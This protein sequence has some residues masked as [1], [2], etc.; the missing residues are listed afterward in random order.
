MAGGKMSP[1]QKMIN[2]MYL[3]LIALLALNVSKEIIKAFNLMENSLNTSTKNL[4]AKNE[5][6]LKAIK[7]EDKP[8]AKAAAVLAEEAKKI[9][10]GFLKQINSVKADLEANT[11][12]RK[13]DDPDAMLVKGGLAELVM[14]DNMEVH[15]N[16][17]LL[18]K[19]NERRDGKAFEF[20]PSGKMRGEAVFDL[21]NKARLDLLAVLDKAAK[22]PYLGG[23]DDKGYTKNLLLKTKED[24]SKKTSLIA[25]NQKDQDGQTREWVSMYL[26]HS[27]LAGVFALLSKYQNDARALESEITTKLAESVN[28]S[29]IKFDKTMAVISTPSSA[30]L[31]GQT[32]EADLILAAYDSKSDLKITAGGSAVEVKEGVGKYKVTASSPGE[33]TYKVQIAVPQPGGGTELKEAEGK[34][35]VFPPIAA[36]SADELNV[37]YVGLDNPISVAVAGVDSRNV[38]VSASAANL[39][40]VGAGRYKALIPTRRG[41]ECIISVVAKMGDGRSVSM[42]SKRFRIRNVPKPVFRA[43]GI[44]FDRPVPLSNLRIQTN[45]IALLENFVYEGVKF[46]IQSFTFIGIGRTGPKKVNCTGSS[47]APIQGILSNMRS[48]EFVMFTDIRAIGPGGAGIYLENASTTLQ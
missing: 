11:D 26:E 18:E 48:G 32:Y 31:Q 21:I 14:G 24:L 5:L 36:I 37:F 2:M 46:Q 38:A 41:N 12:G 43:G 20:N 27:P 13:D 1:R 22:D 35:T 6:A 28:A 25:E 34:Y 10:D 44:A 15:S 33:F 7:A 3:V 42:G 39:V 19:G 47:L 40:N 17:F 16:Y 8:D 4:E 30:V 29:K 45:A 9:S 23:R